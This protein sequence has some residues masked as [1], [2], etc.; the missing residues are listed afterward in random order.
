MKPEHWWFT[1]PLRL[2]SLFPAPRVERPSR[3]AF[4]LDHDREESGLSPEEA[5]PRALLSMG[6]LDQRKERSTRCVTG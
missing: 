5:R 1:A 4:H 3:A 2:R 6:G